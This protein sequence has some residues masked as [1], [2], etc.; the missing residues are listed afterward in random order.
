MY[1]IVPDAIAA[2][3]DFSVLWSRLREKGH[4]CVAW[5]ASDETLILNADTVKP[6][7][8]TVGWIMTTHALS[9]DNDILSPRNAGTLIRIAA[10]L[11]SSGVRARIL[12]SAIWESQHGWK[13]GERICHQPDRDLE[14]RLGERFIVDLTSNAVR[15]TIWLVERDGGL[16][17][18]KAFSRNF[19]GFLENELAARRI[20]GDERIVEISEQ[21]GEVLYMPFIH[22]STAWDGRLFS[23]CD[24]ER[25]RAV[26]AFLADLNRTG[27]SMVDIN[28]SA[29]LFD[30]RGELKVVDFEFFVASRP[31]S[32]FRLSCDYSGE[33]NTQRTPKKNGWKRYWYDAIGGRWE[34]IERMSSTRY[35][36][37]LLLHL[38]SYRVPIRAARSLEQTG[39]LLVN[40]ARRIAGLKFTG[41]NAGQFQV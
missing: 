17:I 20:F 23:F 2:T 37:H 13:L 26:R 6:P 22:G 38:I 28:P 15:S 18:R 34:K 11:R 21:Q 10:I 35:R 32:D 14:L 3:T 1:A 33:F 39:K 30:S 27:H 19:R 4:I 16:Y 12:N 9:G 25:V 24:R 41:N 5:I 31:A 7:T 36:V 8:G 40:R 29:F